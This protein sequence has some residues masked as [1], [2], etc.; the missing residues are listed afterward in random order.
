MPTEENEKSIFYI[1]D[2]NGEL[3][4][5][6]GVQDIDFT[7]EEDNELI[8]FTGNIQYDGSLDIEIRDKEAIRKIRKLMKTD[9]EKKEEQRYNRKSFRDFIKNRK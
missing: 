1:E 5:L 9:K 7:I 4:E 2:E 6:K 3:K 8:D